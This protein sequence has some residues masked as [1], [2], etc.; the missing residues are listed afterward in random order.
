MKIQNEELQDQGIKN[1]SISILIIEKIGHEY[2]ER[3]MFPRMFW[4]KNFTTK[5]RKSQNPIIRQSGFNFFPI[6]FP[7]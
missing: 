5:E 2:K 1:R 4:N 7:N 3:K 6:K